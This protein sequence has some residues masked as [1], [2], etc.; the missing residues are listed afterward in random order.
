MK[1][2][3][4][5][6]ITAARDDEKATALFQEIASHDGDVREHTELIEEHEESEQNKE[7]YNRR[8]VRSFRLQEVTD[9]DSPSTVILRLFQRIERLEGTSAFLEACNGYEAFLSCYFASEHPWTMFLGAAHLSKL[10]DLSCSLYV[11][12]E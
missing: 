4:I 8:V 5:F 10:A 9:D 2:S 3:F 11:N 12:V 7:V 1:Y 6:G